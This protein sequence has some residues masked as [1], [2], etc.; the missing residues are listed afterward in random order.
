MSFP[1]S[2]YFLCAVVMQ[3]KD[4][5][6][7]YS[8]FSFTI[9]CA[10]ACMSVCVCVCVCVCVREREYIAF[11]RKFVYLYVWVCVCLSNFRNGILW[12]TRVQVEGR[13]LPVVLH[14]CGVE[15]CASLSVCVC[16]CVCVRVC[17]WE[18]ERGN[19][20]SASIIAEGKNRKC[21]ITSVYPTLIWAVKNIRTRKRSTMVL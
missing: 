20:E 17:V 3:D 5:I 8:L 15:A 14:H 18:R 16:A 2:L 6:C 4:F 11:V 13:F 21:S 1:R 10:R 9:V 19:A 7:W 12:T